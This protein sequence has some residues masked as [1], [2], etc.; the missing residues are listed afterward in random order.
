MMRTGT[1]R[2]ARR[3]GSRGRSRD[4]GRRTP[5]RAGAPP[6]AAEL[7]ITHLGDFVVTHAAENLRVQV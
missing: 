2:G 3:G 7:L 5:R 4:G 6:V 1:S